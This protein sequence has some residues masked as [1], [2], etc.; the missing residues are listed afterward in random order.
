MRSQLIGQNC[1]NNEASEVGRNSEKK[2]KQKTKTKTKKTG[3]GDLE[4]DGTVR[5]QTVTIK[6]G[7]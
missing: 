1:P 2:Q 6:I 7:R 4:L 5:N 3:E